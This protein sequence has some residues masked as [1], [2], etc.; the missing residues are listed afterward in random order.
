MVLIRIKKKHVIKPVCRLEE[1]EEE[2]KGREGEETETGC[3][4]YHM[5]FCR[6]FAN[7]LV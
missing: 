2:E 4:A 3:G 7:P 1:G 5:V 6:K